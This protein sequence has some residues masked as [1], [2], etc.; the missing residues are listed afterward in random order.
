MV[1]T[2]RFLTERGIPVFAHL[3]L[4]PQA[5]HQLGGFR[6][7]GK[8]EVQAA[9]MMED[10]KA[11]RDAGASLLLLEAVPSTLA[12]QITEEVGLPT[13]GI[14]AGVDCSGQVLVVYDMLGVYH[15]MPKFA[16]NF[17][18][19]AGSIQGAVSAYVK[20]VKDKIF[21]APEHTF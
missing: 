13:I 17:M 20:A 19:G 6:V 18:E 3:G 11:L 21:P 15:Y 10:A 1:D 9:Q 14:G 12:K 16:K 8:N 2:V 5:V 4:T 7:Q